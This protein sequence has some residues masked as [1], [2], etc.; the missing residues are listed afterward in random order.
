MDDITVLVFGPLR[1]RVGVAEIHVDGATVQEVWDE[2]V[3]RHPTAAV[4]AS[5]DGP[6]KEALSRLCDLY[7]LH[8]VEADKGFYQEHGRL[9]APRCKAITREVNRLCNKVMAH[10]D[11]LVDAFGIPDAILNAPIGLRDEGTLGTFS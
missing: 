2:L 1:E 11:L 5:E 9:A 7:A 3:R 4:D 8:N 10:S 6:V